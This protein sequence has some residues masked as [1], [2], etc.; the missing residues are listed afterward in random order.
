M[1]HPNYHKPPPRPLDMA[2]R[3][4]E[5]AGERKFQGSRCIHGHSG[6]RYTSSGCCVDC[7]ILARER[8]QKCASTSQAA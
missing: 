6:I 1:T 5:L 8:K 2:K 3:A 7:T 4:A